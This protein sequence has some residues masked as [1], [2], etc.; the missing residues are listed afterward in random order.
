MIFHVGPRDP[1]RLTLLEKVKMF[2][3]KMSPNAFSTETNGNLSRPS[4]PS[5]PR[6]PPRYR[7]YDPAIEELHDSESEFVPSQAGSG[8]V[9]FTD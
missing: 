6:L 3:A 9:S 8:R 1:E 4:T 5:T 2:F 7:E